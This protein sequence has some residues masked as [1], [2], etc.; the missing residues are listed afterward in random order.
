M[1]S[2][3]KVGHKAEKKKLFEQIIPSINKVT[4]AIV[5]LT[6]TNL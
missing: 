1:L 5:T 3:C 4:D 2:T 6:E